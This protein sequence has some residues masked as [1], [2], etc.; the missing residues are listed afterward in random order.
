MTIE[1]IY[2][3]ED[4]SV[5]TFNICKYNGLNDLNAIIEY[6]NKYKAFDNLRNCG[7][8]SNEELVALSQKY[9]EGSD[10]SFAEI[11][12]KNDE[13]NAMVN[14]LTRSQR[15]LVNSFIDINRNQLSFS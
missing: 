6:Y 7:R 15:E 11:R 9:N 3:S 2:Y 13:F 1:E 8:M 12:V 5:R 4:I 10:N 14:D